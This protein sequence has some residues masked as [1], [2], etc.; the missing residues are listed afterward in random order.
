MERKD[1]DRYS[2]SLFDNLVMP[3]MGRDFEYAYDGQY[4]LLLNPSLYDQKV[5]FDV[6]K[7]GYIDPGSLVI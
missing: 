5:G 4:I 7:I 3:A 2:I 6:K 1:V